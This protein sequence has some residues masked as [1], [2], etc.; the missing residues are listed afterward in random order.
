MLEHKVSRK[1]R[2][3]RLHN[4]PVDDLASARPVIKLWHFLSDAH[5]IGQHIDVVD[6]DR[7]LN[8][9]ALR[10]RPVLGSVLCFEARQLVLRRL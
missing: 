5:H 2:E 6:G 9:V 4:E 7:D 8:K 3:S 1:V 10:L